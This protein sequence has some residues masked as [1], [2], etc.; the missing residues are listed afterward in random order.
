MGA[1]GYTRR[2][3][4]TV[5]T[6]RRRTTGPNDDDAAPRPGAAFVLLAVVQATLTG[7]I[8]L[9]LLALPA[10]QRDL[11]LSDATMVL[12]SAGPGL[13]FSG[14]LLLGGR[15]TDMA[16]WR[17]AFVAGLA[18]FGLASAAGALAPNAAL[19]LAARFAQGIGAAL[20][21]PAAM[22]LL[23][24]LFA[25]RGRRTRAVAIWGNLAPLGASLGT[26]LSGVVVSW[27]SWRW[28]FVI[29]LAIA[30]IAVLLA[31]RLLP[32]GPPPSPT[33][34]DVPGAV[35]A[36][37]GLTILSF[38]LVRIGEHA[39]SSPAVVV[40][41]IAGVVL[42]LAFVLVEA[43]VAAPLLPPSFFASPQR[44]AALLIILLVGAVSATLFFMLALYFL[45]VRGWPPLTTSA[46]FLPFAVALLAAGAVAGR[47]VG[48]LGVRAAGTLGL[49]VGAA[50]LA[51]V[52]LVHVASPYAGPILGGLLLFQIGA[53]LAVAAAV[54]V[55]VGGVEAD[56]AGLAGGVINTVQQV[57]PTM[58]L[59][60][61]VSVANANSARLADAGIA[62][63]AA[64]TG[65]YAAAFA[66]A[67]SAFALAAVLAAG[68]LR[69]RPS[70]IEA[71]API[72]I[73][74]A[75]S[76]RQRR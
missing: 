60:I 70:R 53:G 72:I 50:G 54:V 51:L 20:C 68:V 39:W 47:L 63:P 46:A 6:N 5:V 71:A 76:R 35:L 24:A 42:L 16:G 38:G 14:L 1:G 67:A 26:L 10:I 64:T 2:R 27:V 12:V 73:P 59:A 29:P 33:P 41:V 25:D 52:S 37:A 30:A 45:E 36:T 48:R 3:I 21:A 4:A 57:G 23:G 19:L 66:V 32:A 55:A 17:R 22:A 31:P 28:T 8:A 61:L 49:A 56:E 9:T 7:A 15:L 40:P 13:S 69:P 34:L 43:R 62:A 74:R 44:S 11:D 18:V 65:G 58:G 75:G